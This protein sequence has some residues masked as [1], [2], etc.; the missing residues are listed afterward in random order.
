MIG[1]G[2]MTLEPKI[3]AVDFDGDCFSSFTENHDEEYDWSFGLPFFV[4]YYTEF[5]FSDKH[6]SITF[7]ETI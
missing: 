5:N 1:N 7:W 6:E 2:K 3:Y 4:K